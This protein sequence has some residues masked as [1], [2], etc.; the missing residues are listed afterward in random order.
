VTDFADRLASLLEDRLPLVVDSEG[1]E[2]DWNV[3]GP[4]LLAAATRHLRAIKHLQHGFGSRVV[5]WQRPFARLCRSAQ[6]FAFWRLALC[7]RL[8]LFAAAS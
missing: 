3:I 2:D 5:G 1:A 4:A 8:H 7:H 6:P